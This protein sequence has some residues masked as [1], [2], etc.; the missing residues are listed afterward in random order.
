MPKVIR[1]LQINISHQMRSYSSV[2][3]IWWLSYTCFWVT[4]ALEQFFGESAQIS[5]NQ[6]QSHTKR[7]PTSSTPYFTSNETIHITRLSRRSVGRI[8]PVYRYLGLGAIFGKLGPNTPNH[9]QGHMKNNPKS[10]A[11]CFTSNE[12]LL[13]CQGPLWVELYLLHRNS[14][15]RA[16]WGNGFEFPKS[17][18]RTHEK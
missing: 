11:P 1:S 6:I 8:I 13:Y 4:W 14:G 3:I 18:V 16:I 17:C 12:T 2:K 10:S 7:N 9:V 15:I 5:L